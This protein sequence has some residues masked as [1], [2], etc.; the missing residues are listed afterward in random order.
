MIRRPE[1]RVINPDGQQLG[2]QPIRQAIALAQE[3]GL[4]LVEINPKADPPVCR[5]MDFGKFK[6]EQKKQAA[7]AKKRQ[8]IIEIKEVKMRPKTDTHDF[9]FKIKHVR[10]FLEEGNKAK[11]T[12][13]FKG[14]EMAHP[15]MA[16]KL[17]DK[18][19]EACRDI[20]VVEQTYRMEGR[21][22]TMILAPI[23]GRVPT[24]P[25]SRTAKTSDA[26]EA[27]NAAAE[28]TNSDAPPAADPR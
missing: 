4:D 15:D 28:P 6:Y 10:R 11:L 16:A 13:R 22:M 19:V 21:T 14:R 18:V 5:I 24:A 2:I 1:V 8:R 23:P 20:A 17:L 12:I 3:F 7:V 26:P 25:A 27:E 9:D